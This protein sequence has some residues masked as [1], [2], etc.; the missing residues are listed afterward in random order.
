MFPCLALNYLG[1]GALVLHN[2]HARLNPFCRMV[3]SLVYW[4][5]LILATLATVIASQA[6]ITGAFSMTQ[7]AVQLGLLPRIYIKRTSETQAGQIFVPA[8]NNFL[9]IGVLVLLVVFRDFH[10]LASAYGIAVTGAMFVD[11]LLA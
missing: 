10:R 1:Q 4:P 8:V 3:P 6:V 7:Q 11:T 9:M 5:I 2:P